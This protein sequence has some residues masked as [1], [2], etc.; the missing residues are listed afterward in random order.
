MPVM[1]VFRPPLLKGGGTARR[2]W[3]SINMNP[4]SKYLK[5]GKLYKWVRSSMVLF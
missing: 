1:V 5:P 4:I 3:D 2:W